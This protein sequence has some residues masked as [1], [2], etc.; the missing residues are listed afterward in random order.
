VATPELPPNPRG[1][2]NRALLLAT[3][4]FAVSFSAWSL[5]A[6]LAKKFQ[7]TLDL[8]NTRTLLLTAVPVILGSLLRIPVGALT[9]RYGGRTMFTVI[10]VVSAVPAAL[11]GFVDGYWGL[12]LVGFF[13]GIAGTSFAVGVPFVAGWFPKERQGFALGVYGMGNI[14]TAVAAFG[15][16]AINKHWGR[17]TLGVVSGV[18]LLVAAALFYALAE[19][20]PRP[21]VPARYADVIRAGWRLYRLALLYF[22][23][24]G[25]FVA[26][27]IFLP[28]LLKDW[29]GY[30]LT[31]AG[32]RAAGFT[33]V[34]T[35]A[36]PAGGWLSDRIGATTVLAVAF[37]GVGINAAAL[38]VLAGNPTI[39]PVTITCLTLAAFLGSGNGAVF[40]LVPHEFPNAT[41]AATGIVGAA[42]GL[43]GFFPPI[44]M[45]IVKDHFDTYALGFVGLL[46]FCLFCLGIVV[47]MGR[48]V[49]VSPE[50]V[51]R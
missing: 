37:V 45:G 33:V 51:A 14:G 11:F 47:A 25:G 32:L 2:A 22:V 36:R 26:M 9:D 12:I 28:K 44:V 46:A 40:K 5:I 50:L 1:G 43:G 19:N 18:V 21:S 29:F 49:P 34:A 8:S 48:N 24:F 4:A 39:V 6:P 38:A 42:G 16:P 20:P 30:S 7:E 27:A 35:L 17:P 3:V 31:D 23:T 10:L 15:A 13:L 41:G